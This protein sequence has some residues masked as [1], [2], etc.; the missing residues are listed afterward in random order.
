MLQ[1][2]NREFSLLWRPMS[3]VNQRSQNLEFG[4]DLTIPSFHC[5]RTHPQTSS[6]KKNTAPTLAAQKNQA[7]QLTRIAFFN[8]ILWESLE[9]ILPWF[10]RGKKTTKT[11]L[12][13]SLDP[14]NV[15][16]LVC[17]QQIGI[18]IEAFSP[19]LGMHRTACFCWALG[20]F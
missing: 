3:L 15:S 8:Y 11:L 19:G 2:L 18:V 17:I 16:G 7:P 6:L 9:R 13:Q 5:Y 10:F 1:W 14:S 20:Q 12:L 4:M